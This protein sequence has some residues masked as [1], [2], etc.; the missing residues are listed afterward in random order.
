MS[1]VLGQMVSD[2]VRE[3]SLLALW[4][5]ALRIEREEGKPQTA[6]ALLRRYP[7]LANY[8]EKGNWT[9]PVCYE[10]GWTA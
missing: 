1:K 7:G 6:E 5:E 4:V 8:D 10:N 3:G 2:P 9:G